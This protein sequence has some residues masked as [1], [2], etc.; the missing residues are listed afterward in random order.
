MKRTWIIWGALPPVLALILYWPT[1]SLPI[2]YDDLLHIRITKSLTLSNVWLPTEEFGFYRPLTFFPLLVIEGLW[3]YY[4][5]GILHASNILQHA[6]NCLL[7][8]ALVWRLGRKGE[9]A[10]WAGV[11]FAVYP[12]SYQ[13]IAIYGHN[14]HPTTT[15]LL[16]LGLHSY[17]WGVKTHSWHW[18]GLTVIWF[19]LGLLS[20]ESAILFGPFAFL[21]QWAYAGKM[22]LKIG[23]RLTQINADFLK[24]GW[25]IFSVLGAVYFVAYQFLPLS[26]APQAT[27]SGGG[28]LIKGLYLFQ[29]LSFPFAWL[30]QFVPDGAKTAVVGVGV[31]AV[32]GLVGWRWRDNVSRPG[33]ILALG[34]WGLA[35]LVIAIP[36]STNY[37]LHGSRL[38][39]LSS[40]G[41]VLLW[42]FLF[43][44]TSIRTTHHAPRLF[45]LFAIITSSL[46]VTNRLRAYADLTSPVDV[47][48]EEMATRPGE[49]GILLI[50]L[51]QWTAPA[52]NTYPI[53]VELVAML[54]DYLFVEELMVEN[55]GIDRPI[56]AT[57]LPELLNNPEDYTFGT[58]NQAD[59]EQIEADWAPAGSHVFITH[60]QDTGIHTTYTGSFRLY[61][62]P[63]PPIAFFGGYNLIHAYTEQ[64]DGLINLT[65]HWQQALMLED[66][67][68]AIRN[69]TSLFVQLL[70]PNGQVIAQADGPPLGL[71]AD[72]VAISPLGELIDHRSLDPAGA[73]PAHIILGVYDFATGE[74]YPGRD[75]QQNILP[76]YAYTVPLTPC[77]E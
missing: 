28:L 49:E 32:F 52:Q 61:P 77:E 15:S 42:A 66:T 57:V 58:H 11:L 44:P 33:L 51:P 47:V 31:V 43:Y 41:T 9:Q 22:P 62:S 67:Q 29:G 35:S 63:T 53:G 75:T 65:T 54:G 34:W 37:L 72:L 5:A 73:E 25:F 74:R 60:Y 55:L 48:A 2:I 13:A 45:A 14:V 17:L 38:L 69:T 50:N 19:V 24:R 3:G 10:L 39:Y 18:W 76:N 46:F 8:S 70:S 27:L 26:R 64:C 7:I 16:L 68:Y 36:L 4:P 59:L 23:R 12:F 56:Q 40:V 6:L 71:R 21:V 1:L 30:G 20:H